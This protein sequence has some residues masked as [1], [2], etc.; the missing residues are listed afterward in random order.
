MSEV[1]RIS[2][3]LKGWFLAVAR[4]LPWRE[5]RDPY[6]TWVAEVMLQ[7]TQSSVV[8]PYFNLWME[9]FPT[10][11]HLASSPIEGVLK[12]WEGLGYYS[13]AKNLHE[14]AK[15]IVQ[16]GYFPQ[17]EELLTIKGIGPY[18]YKAILSF[19]FGKRVAPVDGNVARVISRLFGLSDCIEKAATKRAI[20]QAAEGLLPEENPEIVA[21]SLI[22]L[23]ATVCQKRPRC[24]KC[25]I[26]MGCWAYRHN[27]QLELPKVKAR[28]QTIH[29]HRLVAVIE[30]QGDFLI[31]RGEERKVMEYLLEFPYVESEALE[32]LM[33]KFLTLDIDLEKNLQKQS[34]TFTKYRAH[35]TPY[36]F[37][38]RNKGEIAGC[39]WM[40]WEEMLKSPFS[41]GHRKI[42][43]EIACG[44]YTQKP[45]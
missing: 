29:L 39:H 11:E 8:I 3:E 14:G 41:S 38:A 7:Q 31:K 25:P 21:E 6:A 40:S 18:T 2:R 4:D 35:L 19:A 10:L 42:W 36:H 17:D 26:K 27:R 22:E 12:A 32:D 37:R 24:G 9:R 15:Q 33:Q 30:H 44:L 28:P 43:E 45:L 13:R 34:H 5:K 1:D 20:S 16:K 23:G